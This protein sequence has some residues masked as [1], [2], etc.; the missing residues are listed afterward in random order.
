MQLESEKEGEQA[1]DSLT[2]EG[3]G[4]K[5]KGGTMQ[6]E[7]EKVGEQAGRDSIAGKGVGKEAKGGIVQLESQKE[8]E[9]A[10]QNSI[11][12]KGAG[13]K[14]KNGKSKTGIKK[15][16]GNGET[17]PGT[18]ASSSDQAW[19]PDTANASTLAGDWNA[20]GKDWVEKTLQHYTTGQG[21]GVSWDEIELPRSPNDVAKVEVNWTESAFT[22]RDCKKNAS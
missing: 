12:G 5:A 18:L 11:A 15:H 22:V 6:L 7:S 9:Q 19:P 8:G 14:G 1:Q 13:K 21:N 3:A 2:A 10:G 20:C 16:S 4:K 17:V